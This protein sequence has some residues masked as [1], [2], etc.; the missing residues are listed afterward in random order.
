MIEANFNAYANYVTDSL[1][2]WDRNQILSVSGLNISTAP[3]VHFY[4]SAMDKAIVK[5]ATFIDRVVTVQIP[6]SLLQNALE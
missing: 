3:E 1:Y 6:N 5:Q 2:Q 4:N